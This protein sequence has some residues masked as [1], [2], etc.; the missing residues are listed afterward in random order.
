MN[1]PNM[2]PVE[3]AH[4]TEVEIKDAQVIN[5]RNLLFSGAAAEVGV[6]Q[7]WGFCHLIDLP[8]PDAIPLITH[9]VLHRCLNRPPD[10][11]IKFKIER[12]PVHRQANLNDDHAA[13]SCHSGRNSCDL[14]AIDNE[15]YQARWMMGF[16]DST[17][18]LGRVFKGAPLRVT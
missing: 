12:S 6:L 16:P 5:D 15:K 10:V 17:T 9:C 4:L 14:L 1:D 18:K 3:V 11:G 13:Y 8:H 2:E 7:R